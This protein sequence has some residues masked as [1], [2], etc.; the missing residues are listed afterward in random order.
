MFKQLIHT[1]T[2]PFRSIEAG[3]PFSAQ[4]AD[5]PAMEAEP[6]KSGGEAPSPRKRQ[7][8]TS[9]RDSPP[10]ELT[11][12]DQSL[13]TSEGLATNEGNSPHRVSPGSNAGDVELADPD[14]D[15]SDQKAPEI[16]RKSLEKRRRVREEELAA[17]R[18]DD[19]EGERERFLSS[20]F[21][22]LEDGE[23]K[24]WELTLTAHVLAHKS[25][26]VSLLLFPRY[27]KAKIIDPVKLDLSLEEKKE[28]FKACHPVY[29]AL[30]TRQLRDVSF[31][32]PDSSEEVD[33]E[34]DK[35]DFSLPTA[36]SAE[37]T[38]WGNVA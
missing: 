8:P 35:A 1:L 22:M 34:S 10:K 27:Q 26:G 21:E 9:D 2:K 23:G 20:V 15:P 30:C 18:S 6:K 37:E 13:T 12:E 32:T 31:E 36:S 5:L 38:D 11:E 4:S 3:E 24:G 33:D 17:L 29:E 7:L 25:A 16:F 19:F 28:L 14:G